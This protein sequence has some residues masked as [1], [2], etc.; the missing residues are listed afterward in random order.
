MTT[1]ERL[2]RRQIRNDWFI[3]IVALG[4]VLAFIYFRGRSDASDH[5]LKT[6]ISV[7]SE[8]S[9][10]RAKLVERESKTTRAFLLDAT[11]VKTREDFQKVR[12]RYAHDLTAI[13]HAR[14]AHPIQPFPKGVCD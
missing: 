8:T 3:A 7:Q 12:A 6:F 14:K 5:C 11:A 2:R 9:A 4:L 1:P 10:I 13:D